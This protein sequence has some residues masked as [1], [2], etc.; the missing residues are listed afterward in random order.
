MWRTTAIQKRF[1]LQP[2]RK[3]KGLRAFAQS[4]LSAGLGILFRIAGVTNGQITRRSGVCGS[5]TF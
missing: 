2:H 5:R 4:R 3:S 1:F